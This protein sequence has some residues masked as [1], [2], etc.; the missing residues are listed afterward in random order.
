[1][2]NNPWISCSVA[3][4]NI[5]LI[6]LWPFFW[7]VSSHSQ[8]SKLTSTFCKLQSERAGSVPATEYVKILNFK[9]EKNNT[10]TVFPLT[11]RTVQ[12]FFFFLTAQ[13]FTF[14]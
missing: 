3:S 5:S 6:S 11:L 1:M 9:A 8:Y 14:Y 4:V 12:C 10:F 2:R 13:L 7:I